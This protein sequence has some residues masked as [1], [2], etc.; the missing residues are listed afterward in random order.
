MKFLKKMLIPVLIFHS[1][2]FYAIVG[3]LISE[4]DFLSKEEKAIKKRIENMG[5]DEFEH[6][7]NIFEG[8]WDT[9]C[10]LTPYHGWVSGFESINKK[11]EEK[12]RNGEIEISEGLFQ[13]LFQKKQDFY[14][15]SYSRRNA[16]FFVKQYDFTQ[17]L[18]NKFKDNKFEPGVPPDTCFPFS[19]SI[20]FKFRNNNQIYITLGVKT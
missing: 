1:V 3:L 20:I 15:I 14:H 13:I 18:K 5:Y 7:S 16:G 17:R 11:I 6:A 10:V 12:E 8:S 9:I 4:Y 2:V 19:R